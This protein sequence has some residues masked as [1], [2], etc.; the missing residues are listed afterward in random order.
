[1]VPVINDVY[2]HSI[3]DPQKESSELLKQYRDIL[4]KSSSILILGLGYGY[5][6]QEILRYFKSNNRKFCISVL[7]PSKN[8][9]QDCLKYNRFQSNDIKI[10]CY[11]SLLKLFRSINFVKFILNKPSIIPHPPSFNLYREYFKEYFTYKFDQRLSYNLDLIDS[12]E[13][14]DYFKDKDKSLSL[15]NYLNRVHKNKSFKQD[16][17]FILSAFVESASKKKS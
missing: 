5:H 9:I 15:F 17:D 13:M 3:Y 12:K 8:I 10:Y 16:I 7:E 4:D 14:R 11:P 1:M 2:L 6:V